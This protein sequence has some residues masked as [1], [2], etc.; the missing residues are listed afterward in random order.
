MTMHGWMVS[1]MWLCLHVT[2]WSNGQ[3]IEWLWLC[4][5]GSPTPHPPVGFPATQV[6]NSAVLSWPWECVYKRKRRQEKEREDTREREDKR[7]NTREKTRVKTRE[8]AREGRQKRKRRP[9]R[10]WDGNKELQQW[11][12]A[13][14]W[15]NGKHT[16]TTATNPTNN[17]TFQTVIHTAV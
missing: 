14:A 3:W 2:G 9:E 12:L 5:T 1:C 4:C 17:S 15:L 16:N 8:K 7:E 13:L 10:C 6:E 11:R